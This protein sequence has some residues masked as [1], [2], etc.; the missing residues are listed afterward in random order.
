ME[1]AHLPKR[2]LP[3]HLDRLKVVHTESASFQSAKER[4]FSLGKKEFPICER[5]SFQSGEERVEVAE[6]HNQAE[7]IFFPNL[8]NSVSL[9]AC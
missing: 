4:L 2:T 6:N 9:V 1:E 8:R 5:E 7:K 3:D